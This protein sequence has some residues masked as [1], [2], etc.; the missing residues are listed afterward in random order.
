MF[1][2]NSN[3]T[4]LA[5]LLVVSFGCIKGDKDSPKSEGNF[6][7]RIYE[8]LGRYWKEESQDS[9]RNLLSDNLSDLDLHLSTVSEFFFRNEKGSNF[10]LTYEN[11]ALIRFN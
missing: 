3:P 8:K 7:D 6:Q 4:L 1:P 2:S 9:I 10:W 11:L 5:F